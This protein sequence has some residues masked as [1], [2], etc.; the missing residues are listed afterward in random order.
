MKDP[1][2]AFASVAATHRRCFWLDGGGAREWSGRRSI[3]GWLDDDDVS[4]TYDAASG[5]VVRHTSGRAEPVGDDV[6]AVLEQELASGRPTDQWFGY[7]GYAA[8]PDLPAATG[9][10]LPDAVWM[11]ARHVQMFDHPAPAEAGDGPHPA[12]AAGSA[13]GGEGPGPTSLRS[14]LAPAA[15]PNH[16]P[17]PP[18]PEPPGLRPGGSRP[19]T[20]PAPLPASRNICTPATRTR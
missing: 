6:F 15:R 8:R 17:G 19:A 12:T 14:F 3:I 9:S 5:E 1:V 7:F 4:L 18:R 20:T 10:G 11:R 16:G 2:A 13:P